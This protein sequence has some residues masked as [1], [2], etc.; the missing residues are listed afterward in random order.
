MFTGFFF[1]SSNE[2]SG[3]GVRFTP[4]PTGVFTGLCSAGR[5][6]NDFGLG[7]PTRGLMR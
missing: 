2:R 6:L 3:T 1:G 5:M 7:E 4:S